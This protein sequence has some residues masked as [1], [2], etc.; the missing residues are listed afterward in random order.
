MTTTSLVS[1]LQEKSR[2]RTLLSGGKPL[3]AERAFALVRDMPY[4]R[5]SSR[6]PE[7]IVEEW[8]GTCSGKHYL[9]ADIFRELGLETRVFMATHRFTAK[10][11]SHFPPDLRALVAHGPVP[12]V[13]TYLSV[14]TPAG[15]TLVDATWPSSAAP[16]GMPVNREF[17]PGADMTIACD[18]I[19]SLPVPEGEDPQQFKEQVIARF[20]GQSSQTRDDFIEGLGRWLGDST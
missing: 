5:A 3:T 8:R 1:L 20:C 17:R 12:D 19:E 7:A 18:P 2:E 11:T 10:N 6:R 15:W 4:R 9:L 13:H 14:S 16:L